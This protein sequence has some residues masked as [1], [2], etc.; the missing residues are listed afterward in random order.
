[1]GAPPLTSTSNA[2]LPFIASLPEVTGDA[3]PELVQAAAA[4]AGVHIASEPGELIHSIFSE[5]DAALSGPTAS[6]LLVLTTP[7]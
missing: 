7:R 1:M 3:S 4:A 6:P 2:G 5:A